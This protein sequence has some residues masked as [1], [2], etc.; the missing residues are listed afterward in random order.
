M[1]V[2][3]DDGS[4]LRDSKGYKPMRDIVQFVRF[5]QCK[6]DPDLLRR[7]VL[8]EL[9]DQIL[10]YF[11]CKEIL[12]NKLFEE[13]PLTN[14]QIEDKVI[15]LGL[16]KQNNSVSKNEKHDDAFKSLLNGVMMGAND[17]KNKDF[18]HVSNQEREG[19]EF[20]VNENE[21]DSNQIK[22]KNFSDKDENEDENNNQFKK[23]NDDLIKNSMSEFNQPKINNNQIKVV[24]K[25]NT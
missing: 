3:D 21:N 23:E 16:R 14:K 22:D 4:T 2:F 15:K 10:K 9:P 12:P 5:N 25:K 18:Y 6:N 20:K 17:D 11:K 7:E 19:E 24:K 8:Y 13:N 1:D